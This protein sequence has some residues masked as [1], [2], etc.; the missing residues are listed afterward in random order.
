M[1]GLLDYTYKT[2]DRLGL[3]S[4]AFEDEND[5]LRRLQLSGNLGTSSQDDTNT[6]YGSGRVGYVM[7]VNEGNLTTGLHF[8]GYKTEG[9]D[10]KQKDFGLQGIDAAFAKGKNT[11]GLEYFPQ[12]ILNLFY[13]R[14][15]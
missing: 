8:G 14:D 1:A 12:Q 10:F 13:R 3:L 6:L 2:P 11:Y 4:N 5:F 15:F 9:D 7:P